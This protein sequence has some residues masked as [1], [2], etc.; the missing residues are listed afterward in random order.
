MRDYFNPAVLLGVV[1][2]FAWGM[3]DGDNA[4]LWALAICVSAFLV[5][6]AL[7]LARML[8][9]RPVLM[10][11]VWA[12]AYLILSSC[13]W[14][15]LQSP[16]SDIYEEEKEALQ[17]RLTEWKELG[18][19][20]FASPQQ[21]QDCLVVLA[22]GLGK[23]KLLRELL[24]LPEAQQNIGVLQLAAATAVENGQ[25]HSLQLLLDFGVSA[26]SSAQGS[27]LISTAVINGRH[28]IAELLLMAGAQP[29]SPDAEGIPPIMHAVINNDLPT[30]RLLMQYGADASRKAPNGR[31][32]HSCSRSEEMDAILNKQ[33]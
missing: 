21:E 8:A 15:M 12:A 31:G 9:H 10:G 25:K 28:D 18:Y 4:G 5:N 2:L 1:G 29:D 22:A 13:A 14:V 20:P 11:V 30:A 32:A 33:S 17:L 6:A 27:S 23:G 19:S 26:D 24:K 16:Q 7:S 3:A